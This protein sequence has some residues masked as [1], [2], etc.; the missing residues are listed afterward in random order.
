MD[1]GKVDQDLARIWCLPDQ[2]QK[3]LIRPLIASVPFPWQ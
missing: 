2:Y 1:S 3:T